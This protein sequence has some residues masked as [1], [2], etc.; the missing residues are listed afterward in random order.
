MLFEYAIIK[1]EKKDKDG[2]VTEKAQ[3]LVDVTRVLAK[4]MAQATTIAAR[5][6]PQ[7]IIDDGELDR[8][9]VAVRPF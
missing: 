4:D 7:D 3:V 8:I 2:A 6:I 1:D 9:Q 5:A